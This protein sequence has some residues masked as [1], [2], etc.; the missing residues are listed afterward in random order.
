MRREPADAGMACRKRLCIILFQ[1]AATVHLPVGGESRS[2]I[3]MSSLSARTLGALGLAAAGLFAALPA[4]SA[5]V[6]LNGWAFGQGHNVRATGYVGE[7]GGSFLTYCIEIEEGFQFGANALA[8][9]SLVDGRSYFQRRRG[10]AGI[11]DRLGDLL[12]RAAAT[13]TLVDSSHESTSMQI[14]VWNLI[15]DTDLNATARS[16]FRETAGFGGYAT[17]LLAALDTPSAV[18]PLRIFALEAAGTQDFLIA[19]PAAPAQNQV[20]LPATLA[21]SLLGLAALAATRRAGRA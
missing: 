7:A 13:P 16:A 2:E 6:T 8:S 20:P 1:R 21:L 15:Y 14:A 5:S 18:Q 19:L 9:Y 4:Q 11:A 12:A 3:P 10:D 17:T